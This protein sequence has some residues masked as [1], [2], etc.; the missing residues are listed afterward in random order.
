MS[1]QAFHTGYT[2]PQPLTLPAQTPVP[3]TP[4]AEQPVPDALISGGHTVS[5]VSPHSA[6]AS[7]TT[8]SVAEIN[9]TAIEKSLTEAFSSAI[10]LGN[11]QAAAALVEELTRFPDSHDA[12]AVL[13]E[14][15]RICL[16]QFWDH[17]TLQIRD[18]I[19]K[20]LRNYRDEVMPNPHPAVGDYFY[21]KMYNDELTRITAAALYG[22]QV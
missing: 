15:D 16:D 3:T 2:S 21:R 6:L 5:T 13:V 4:S 19:E 8:G 22:D 20:G 7:P 10:E 9:I 14:W 11:S 17:D 12:A 1:F 18:Q